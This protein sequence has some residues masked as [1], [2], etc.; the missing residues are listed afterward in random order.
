M[1]EL[2]ELLYDE[3]SVTAE[4][5]SVSSSESHLEVE[6]EGIIKAFY[7]KLKEDPEYTCCSCEKLLL[8]KVT[9]CSISFGFLAGT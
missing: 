6:F 3:E 7:D 9:P 1:Q 5:Q 4:A 8:K 2:S